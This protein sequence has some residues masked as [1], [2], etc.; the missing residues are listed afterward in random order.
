M[1]NKHQELQQQF[2][3][4]LLCLLRFNFLTAIGNKWTFTTTTETID[5]VS[6]RPSSAYEYIH[7]EGPPI[8]K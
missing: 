1:E 3:K 4:R 7:S 8:E 2:M 5:F 6:S